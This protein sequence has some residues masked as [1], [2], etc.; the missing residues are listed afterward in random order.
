MRWQDRFFRRK[1][2]ERRLQAELAFHL[3]QKT[4]ELIAAGLEPEEARRRARIDFGSLDRCQEACRESDS[5]AWPALLGVGAASF[6]TALENGLKNLNSVVHQWRRRPGLFLLALLILS[7]G[8]GATSAVYSL[9]YAVMMRPLSYP[10]PNRIVQIRGAEEPPDRRGLSWWGQGHIFKWLAAEQ[11]RNWNLRFGDQLERIHGARVSRDFFHVFQIH[12]VLGHLDDRRS[13][14]GIVL[15]YG[16]WKRQFGSRPDVLGKVMQLN[17]KPYRI[18][19]VAPEN[20]TYPQ[21]C[22]LWILLPNRKFGIVS[23][24]RLFPGVTLAQANTA[25]RALMTRAAHVFAKSGITYGG[26]IGAIRLHS[27]LVE[28]V[29]NSLWLVLAGAGCLLFAALIA[30]ASLLLAQTT[31]RRREFALRLALGAKPHQINMQLLLEGAWLGLAACALG[32]GMAWFAIHKL[33]PWL[34]M[35]LP[36][37]RVIPWNA[38]VLAISA[39]LALFT[40]VAMNMPAALSLPSVSPLSTLRQSEPGCTPRGVRRIQALLVTAAIALSMLLLAAAGLLAQT[41]WRTS[42]SLHGF[43]TRGVLSAEI[44]LPLHLQK[45]AATQ[46]A[47]TFSQAERKQAVRAQLRRS[48]ARLR[49]YMHAVE[50]RL[51]SLPGVRAAG[52][53]DWLPLTQAREIW[54]NPDP[55]HPGFGLMVYFFAIH[56]NYFLALHIPLIRG[57]A[58]GPYDGCPGNC[59]VVVSQELARK[60]WLKQNPIG[61]NLMVNGRSFRVVGEVGEIG[62]HTGFRPSPQIY[63]PLQPWQ[64][65]A[66]APSSI[67]FFWVA[68]V[69]PPAAAHFPA[70]L[71]ALASL[72][73]GAAPY[74]ARTMNQVAHRWLFAARLR[75]IVVV[76]FAGMALWLSMGGIFG[77]LNFWVSE[78]QYENSIRAALGASS[79]RIARSIGA[80]GAGLAAS[81]IVLGIV[82]FTG[83]RRLLGAFVFQPKTPEAMFLLLTATA[84]FLAA[85]LACLPAI[86]RAARNNPAILLRYE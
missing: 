86:W 85:L 61:R 9:A 37:A 44:T 16:L 30:A 17:G 14:G 51:A 60:L 54:V 15:S 74:H 35:L 20:S 66:D 71:H 32:V 52:A 53:V 28:P 72:S 33:H 23:V 38:N 65:G 12:A 84:A 27:A 25:L 75:M 24:G 58:L 2:A 81:G 80:A 45:A 6:G 48:Q 55:E 73:G 79:W 31:A 57:R 70:F 13:L 11:S 78:R 41:W 19:A 5:A 62:Y 40:S 43:D 64:N 29:A 42:D 36:H 83:M 67:S 82:V 39:G 3:D 50:T 1:R 21:A 18:V 59:A 46:A 8:I 76:I 68:R 69:Q 63:V 7:L 10:H 22:K 49:T 56:G 26:S 34:R 4:A 47:N 77:L